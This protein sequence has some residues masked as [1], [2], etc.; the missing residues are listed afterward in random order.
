M[1]GKNGWHSPS[2]LNNIFMKKLF[3]CLALIIFG[4]S[5]IAQNV[6]VGTTSP[7]PSAILD[8][9]SSNKGLLPPRMSY[10]EIL[11]IPNPAQGLI[12]YD[13]SGRV[14]RMFNGTEWVILSHQKKSL[15]DAPGNFAT[16]AGATT[17][18]QIKPAALAL[19]PDNSIYVTGSYTGSMTI[20]NQTINSQGDADIFIFKLLPG[21]TLA[22]LNS[23]G[24]IA[25]DE[26]NSI[27]IDTD[28]SFIIV[29]HFEQTVDFDPGAGVQNLVHAGAGDAFYAKYNS[30][31]SWA[32]SKR[33]GGTGYDRAYSVAI[34]GVA[35]YIGGYFTG[36]GATFNPTV[37]NSNSNDMFL[38]RY[39]TS[40]GNLGVNGWVKQVSGAGFQTASDMVIQSG[41]LH[42]GG[43]FAT[44]TDFGGSSL[45]SAGS[46][47]GFF[48]RYGL[49][50]VFLSA[51]AISGLGNQYVLEIDVDPAGNII[52]GGFFE[53]TTDFNPAVAINNISSYT[54]ST[55]DG[56]IA[57]YSSLG[58]YIWAKSF[59]NSGDDL[60]RSI[61][62]QPNGQI[63]AMGELYNTSL[64][65]NGTGEGFS[66]NTTAGSADA[67]LLA[68]NSDG[69]WLW[70]QLAG[71]IGGDQ[72]AAVIP[73][74]AGTALL[75]TNIASNPAV[76]FAGEKITS[77]GFDL[78][79]YYP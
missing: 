69:I 14:L 9:K 40:D 71:G 59:G 74:Q 6:G 33:V 57:K 25:T 66:L 34:S 45:T 21:G 30:T 7:D 36:T 55:S 50:G 78:S 32:W 37:L 8:L 5:A 28:G 79:V 65:Y 76:N 61:S 64:F 1:P 22:W 4:S 39:Q 11:A 43:Y 51:H 17:T 60:V 16:M 72:A 62:V 10:A 24:G 3:Y 49:N 35:V 77:Q 63:F 18:G 53:E 38:C 47:D 68:L 73:G 67:I 48:A 54:A 2:L 15:N 42:V 27:A 13:S 12:A 23:I 26:T 75:L 58:A 44:T 52:C 19:G 70:G 41:I 56:F 31:G 46:L 29:G 20:G